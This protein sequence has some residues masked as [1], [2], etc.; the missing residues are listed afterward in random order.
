MTK[1]KSSTSSIV[2]PSIFFMHL[3]NGAQFLN[4]SCVAWYPIIVILPLTKM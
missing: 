4:A 3:V 2:A 1:Y